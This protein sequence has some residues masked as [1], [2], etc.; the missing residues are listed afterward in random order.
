MK[1]T[2][3]GILSVRAVNQYRR[4]DVLTYLAL[5]YYLHNSAARQDEW[6][7]HV[8]TDLVL[9]RT[10]QPYYGAQHFKE[11]NGNGGVEHR[12]IFLPGA[13]EAL[14]EAAL[15]DECAKHPDAFA[16]PQCVF[17]YELSDREDRSGIFKHYF[18]GLRERHNAISMACDSFPNG[19]VRYTDIKKYYPSIGKDLAIRVWQKQSEIAGLASYYRELGEKL[20]TDH[21]VSGEPGESSIL[22]GPMFSH[23]IGNLVLREL[24]EDFCNNLPVKYFRYVDDIILVGN[25]A[26]VNTALNTVRQRLSGLGFILHGSASLKSFEVPTSKWLLGR[27][28]FNPSPQ[29]ISWMTLVGDLKRYLLIDRGNRDE[30][31]SAF[32]NEGLRIP[33]RD[34]SGAVHESGYLEKILKWAPH[35]WFRKKT[36]LISVQSLV[37]QA[38]SLRK[39]YN[40]SFTKAIENASELNGFARKRRIPQLRYYASRLIYLATDDTLLS[41]FPIADELSE[42]HFH[43]KVMEAVSTGNINRLLTLGTNAAQAAAQPIRAAGKAVNLTSIDLPEAEQQALAIFLL[44][45]VSVERSS[46]LQ[47]VE[48]EILKF[49]ST[50]VDLALMKSS[51]PFIREL[52]CLHG[53]SA[54]PRHS[55]MLDKVFDEDEMLAMDA[56]DQLQQSY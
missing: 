8:A 53:V 52:S 40:E 33:V 5:R 39:S 21:A 7:K 11:A 54:E 24:D 50:G 9:T 38:L 30:L 41:L 6:A 49:S 4:R 28:D 45:G 36:Q 13:N 22:T 48:S 35:S 20:I 1:N 32:R 47:E 37:S 55:I 16:N 26:E 31:V 23:L 51:D 34:Y 46:G 19:V 27:H 17:S 12:P 15:L 44:N 43:A 29:P 14:A 42:L 56:I 18:I 2:R 25:N 3:P 10:N